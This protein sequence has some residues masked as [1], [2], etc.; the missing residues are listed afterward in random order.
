MQVNFKTEWKSEKMQ[1][2][3][4]D[5]H[6]KSHITFCFEIFQYNNVQIYNSLA[7]IECHPIKLHPLE[8]FSE[9]NPL[10]PATFL[11]RRHSLSVRR[12][13]FMKSS[14]LWVMNQKTNLIKPETQS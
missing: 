14:E 1:E 3:F 7:L 8:I 13:S 11:L 9:S 10:E 4:I 6:L 12:E 5:L 2:Q